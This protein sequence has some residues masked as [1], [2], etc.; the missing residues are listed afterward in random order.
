[1]NEAEYNEHPG[2]R[3]TALSDFCDSPE[4]YRDY[5][6]TKDLEKPRPTATVIGSIVH[7]CLLEGSLL[8]DSASVYPDAFLTSSGGFKAGSAASERKHFESEVK[9]P[10]KPDQYKLAGDIL[11]SIKDGELSRSVEGST[12]REAAF[13]WDEETPHGSLGMKCKVD[14]FY[15]FSTHYEIHDLKVSERAQPDSFWRTARQF[16]YFLQDAHYS[17]GLASKDSRPV[18]FKFWALEAKRPFRI[19]Q[20][21]YTVSCRESAAEFRTDKINQLAECYA[22]GDWTDPKTKEIHNLLFDFTEL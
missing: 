2:L 7:E 22:T 5:Y 14:W 11:D 3:K 6:V 12:G 19:Y 4:L 17:A 10:V 16:R 18:Y 1:M 20:Y 13:F 8:K 15:E 21:E 9:N